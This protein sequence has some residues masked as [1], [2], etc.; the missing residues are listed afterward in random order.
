MQCS[1]HECSL[2]CAGTDITSIG[3]R[4][5]PQVTSLS[6]PIRPCRWSAQSASF[7]LLRALLLTSGPPT[8]S[9]LAPAVYAALKP[10]VADHE[11]DAQLRLAALQ[12]VDE[13]LEDAVR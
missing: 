5:G 11:G 8:V 6:Q 7:L 9:A 4:D 13:L 10:V 2:S 3:T 12:L 1:R